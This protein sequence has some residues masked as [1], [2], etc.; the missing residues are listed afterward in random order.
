MQL[1]LIVQSNEDVLASIVPM[2]FGALPQSYDWNYT[3]TPQEALGGRVLNYIRGH[4]LGGCSSTSMFS[5][6]SLVV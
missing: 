3:T 5:V 4:I 1:I 2:Y 6:M